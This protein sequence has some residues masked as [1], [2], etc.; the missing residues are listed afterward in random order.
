MNY[1]LQKDF[2]N[3]YISQIIKFL[4]KDNDGYIDIIDLIKFLLHQLKYKS[5]KL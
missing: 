1:L 4:D 2:S 5:T 3:K